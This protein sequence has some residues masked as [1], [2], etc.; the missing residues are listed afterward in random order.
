MTI[1][2]EILNTFADDGES[3]IQIEN[4]LRY[5]N[6]S[7]DRDEIRKILIKMLDEGLLKVV[8]PYERTKADFI[9]CEDDDIEEFWFE[10]TTKGRAEWEKIDYPEK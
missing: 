8:F 3:I 9:N 1:W 5:F 2:E 10:L 7:T 4:L 6:I